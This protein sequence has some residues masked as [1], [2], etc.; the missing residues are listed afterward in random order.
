MPDQLWSLDALTKL[1]VSNISSLL[2]ISPNIQKLINLK[3][4]IIS[5]N[6]KLVSIPPEIS[7][8]PDLKTLIL[9]IVFHFIP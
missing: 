7:R 8:L 5:D 2:A 9:G 3:E 6:Q 1:E 4:L